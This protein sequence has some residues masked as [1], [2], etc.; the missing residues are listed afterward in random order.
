MP[1]VY[2]G[3]MKIRLLRA[4]PETLRLHVFLGVDE[5]HLQKSGELVLDIGEY[6]ILGVSG[7]TI[8]LV[9]S[10]GITASET[11]WIRRDGVLH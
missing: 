9:S 3:V 5:E 10:T 4:G 6:P 1:T 7:A 8:T 2:H 11:G